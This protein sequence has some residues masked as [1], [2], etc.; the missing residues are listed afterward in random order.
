M[1]MRHRRGLG[2]QQREVLRELDTRA[3]HDMGSFT[4]RYEEGEVF[5][6]PHPNPDSPGDEIYLPLGT[7][8]ALEQGGFIKVFEGQFQLTA[9]RLRRG[10]LGE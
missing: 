2:D 8:E 5:A 4:F 10:E 3:S 7:L 9:R 1:S 6:L